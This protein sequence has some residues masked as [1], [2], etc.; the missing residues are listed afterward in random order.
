M[1]AIAQRRYGA[2]PEDVLRPQ[3]AGRPAIG[4]DQVLVRVRA[5]AVDRGT[6]Y[7]MSGAA[8]VAAAHAAHAGD[9][10]ALAHCRARPCTLPQKEQHGPG[11][12]IAACHHTMISGTGIL[13]AEGPPPAGATAVQPPPRRHPATRPGHPHE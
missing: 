11:H 3:E 5:T 13:A 6:R 2:A 12:D 4:D 9:P 7:L 8:V 1:R 10:A